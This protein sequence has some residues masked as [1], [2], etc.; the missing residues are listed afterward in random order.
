[1][2]V[3]MTADIGYSIAPGTELQ[4]RSIDITEP[5]TQAVSEVDTTMEVGP[6]K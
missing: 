3:V 6:L 1:M 4:K 5:V 2:V